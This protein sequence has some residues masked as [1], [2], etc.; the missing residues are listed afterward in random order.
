MLDST[1]KIPEGILYA[2]HEFLGQ[3]DECIAV[4]AANNTFRGQHCVLE[5]ELNASFPGV[6]IILLI[7]KTTINFLRSQKTKKHFFST[8]YA[9]LRCAQPKIW[10]KLS[11]KWKLPRRVCSRSQ[12]GMITAIRQKLKNSDQEIGLLCKLSAFQTR[13]KKYFMHFRAF[14]SLL[15]LL[16]CLSTTYDLLKQSK[17]HKLLACFSVYSNSKTLF[18]ISKGEGQMQC[19]NGIRALS[20]LWIVFF[21]TF[22]SIIAAPVVNL[23]Q[24]FSVSHSQVTAELHFHKIDCLGQKSTALLCGSK[25]LLSSWQLSPFIGIIVGFVVL[26]DIRP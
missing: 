19:L 6:I 17:P 24:A 20:M 5:G 25:R 23:T 8:E 18:Q 12:P 7:K 14:L 4:V 3:Y 26:Q 16:A 9:C 22:T 15:V 13:I 2:N 10:T 11:A 21:H 1:A